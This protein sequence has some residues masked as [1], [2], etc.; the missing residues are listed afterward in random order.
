MKNL[1]ENINC[2]LSQINYIQAC[3]Y[4]KY[5]VEGG[6]VDIIL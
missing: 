2:S 6:Q 5:V 4:L 1:G 3:I